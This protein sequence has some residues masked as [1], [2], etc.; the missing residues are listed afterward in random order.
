M[1]REMLECVTTVRE[2]GFPPM[3]ALVYDVFYAA[4]SHFDAILAHVLSPEYVLVPN[5]DVPQAR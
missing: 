3:F 1:Q 2:R 4:F 5:V